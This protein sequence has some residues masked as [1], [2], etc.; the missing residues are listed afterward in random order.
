[1]FSSFLISVYKAIIL[2]QINMQNLDR[3]SYV[4]IIFATK[5][6]R[7][8]QGMNRERPSVGRPGFETRIQTY[9]QSICLD[10]H[11]YTCG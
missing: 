10:I 8:K 5:S 3:N 1:M 6:G 4:N 11:F 9:V 7:P 2:Q